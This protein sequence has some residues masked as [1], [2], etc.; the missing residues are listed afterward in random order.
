MTHRPQSDSM[1]ETKLTQRVLHDA[2]KRGVESLLLR[3]PLVVA[4]SGGAD[5][6]ALLHMLRSLRSDTAAGTLHVAHLEHGFRG[7]EGR[8]DAAYVAD[9]ATTWGLPYT[10]RYVDIPA[11]AAR[12]RLSSEDA[13]RRARYTF[14]ISLARELSSTVTVAHS[15]DDQAET[16]LMSILRG[17]GL[18][19]IAGMQVIGE[20]S[21]LPIEDATPTLKED[22]AIVGPV[23]R[24]LLHVWR[25][26]VEAY[27]REQGLSPRVDST[28]A[29]HEYV[30]NRVRLEL[31]P[32]LEGNFSKGIKEHLSNLAD[33]A[34]GDDAL[35]ERQVDSIWKAIATY[36]PAVPSVHLDR[37]RFIKLGLAMQRRVARR[38][39]G[40][41]AG[42]L[43]GVAFRH[44]ATVVDIF[45]GE[46][47]SP[48]SA[49]LPHGVTAER[50]DHEALLYRRA[51]EEGLVAALE[52]RE[53]RWPVITVEQEVTLRQGEHI[54]LGTGWELCVKIN[55]VEELESTPG[56]LTAH[57]D[58]DALARLGNPALRTR[59]PGDFMQILGM[60][61]HKSLQDMY[62]DAKIPRALRDHICILALPN[63]SEVLWVPG[64]GGRRSALAAITPQTQR[65]LQLTF[66]RATAE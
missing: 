28:N 48:R 42:T 62:V 13:A 4:V 32:Y 15:A 27:C 31:L 11:L 26:E 54:P 57:F 49:H 55:L 9:L 36:D 45:S 14:L 19:G 60:Q 52:R 44:I 35:V 37:A 16:V 58:L 34:A 61:G 64:Q 30:R 5:S 10:V 24:P 3:E 20:V 17:T 25:K 18:T 63:G 21:V 50:R 40:A 65:V 38:A 39:I 2:L 12:H 8:A 59:K 46:G 23:F 7:E 29:E 47:D 1:H 33:I 41:V 53:T 22:A 6:L 66:S 43:D 56:E 51:S